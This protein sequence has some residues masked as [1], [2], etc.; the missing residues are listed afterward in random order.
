MTQYEARLMS[1]L[2]EIRQEV[3]RVGSWV[4]ENVRDAV[5]SLTRFDRARANQTILRDRAVNKRVEELDHL[6]HVFVIRHLPSAGHLRFVS[7]VLRLNVALERIGDYAV[8]ICRETLRL[9]NPLPDELVQDFE[10]LG[11][12]VLMA[13]RSAMTAFVD[14][15][16]EQ[17]AVGRGA[18]RQSNSTFRKVVS[19]LIAYGDTPEAHTSDLF[20]LMVASRVLKRVGDQAENVAEQTSFVV[21]GEAK[22]P[23]HYRILFVDQD[24]SLLSLM[25]EAFAR[26]VFPDDGRFLSCGISPAETFDRGLVEFL[27]S[28]GVDVEGHPS[29]LTEVLDRAAEHFHIIVGIGV[30]PA[31]TMDHVPFRTVV[32]HWD[33]QPLQAAGAGLEGRERYQALSRAVADEVTG[34]VE[35][36]GLESDR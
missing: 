30:D 17:A 19:D 16:L 34:L 10:V 27:A 36:L 24:N 14:G 5:H 9:D 26:E 15:D 28:R 4:A 2:D 22:G 23:K 33:A 3:Q 6:C 29:G 32:I 7:S 1:D 25:A 12:Q 35:T 21:T 13:L 31:D 11:Q 20:S 8:T 18:A